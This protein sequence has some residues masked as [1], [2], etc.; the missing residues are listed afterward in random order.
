MD[1]RIKTIRKYYG[2]T[3]EEFAERLGV[4]RVVVQS[5]EY[6]KRKPSASFVQ[7]VCSKFSISKDWLL[8]GTGDMLLELS[9][10]ERILEFANQVLSDQPESFRLRL[11]SAL[12]ELGPEDWEYLAELSEKIVKK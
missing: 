4:S 1:E 11:V 12:A 7:L 5:Y 10:Q 8:T 3:Q 6:G 9:T 2:L